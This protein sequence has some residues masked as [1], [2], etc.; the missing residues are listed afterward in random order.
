MSESPS[1]VASWLLAPVALLAGLW[2]PRPSWVSAPIE[3]TLFPPHEPA[4]LEELRQVLSLSQELDW[5]RQ[6]CRWLALLCVALLVALGLLLQV[7]FGCCQAACCL[8]RRLTQLR[9]AP[10]ALPEA[11]RPRA[12]GRPAASVTGH[13][14]LESR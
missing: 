3:A 14:V 5:W 11:P 12:K 8:T 6:L 9:A 13:G 1:A 7:L 10:Q 2:L 4:C